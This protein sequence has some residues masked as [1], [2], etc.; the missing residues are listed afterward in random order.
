ALLFEL[1]PPALPALPPLALAEPEPPEL[2]ELALLPLLEPPFDAL[3]ALELL[4]CE[5]AWLSAPFELEAGALAA[6]LGVVLD[7]DVLDT[8]TVVLELLLESESEVVV[9]VVED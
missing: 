3:G 9:V 2:P 5:P 1:E 8:E 7:M 6:L 4:L